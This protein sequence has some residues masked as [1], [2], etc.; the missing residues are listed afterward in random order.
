MTRA[1]LRPPLVRKLLV[2]GTLVLDERVACRAARLFRLD[3]ER[4]RVAALG[5]EPRRRREK[6]R[7]ATMHEF[8]RTLNFRLYAR[9]VGFESRSITST[10]FGASSHTRKRT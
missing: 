5:A 6:L 1:A 4:D 2:F 7:G 3:R 9:Y 10:A 8:G